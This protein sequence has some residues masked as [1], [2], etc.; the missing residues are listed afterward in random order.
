MNAKILQV[1]SKMKNEE[2]EKLTK[3][4]RN[5][6]AA[7]NEAKRKLKSRNSDEKIKWTNT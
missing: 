2:T 1:L 7:K 4:T 3:I 6:I 5:R